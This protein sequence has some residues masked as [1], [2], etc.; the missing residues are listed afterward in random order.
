[1]VHRDVGEFCDVGELRPG[2]PDGA[3]DLMR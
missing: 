1:M 2:G 3:L